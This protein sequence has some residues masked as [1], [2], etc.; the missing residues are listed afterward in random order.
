MVVRLPRTRIGCAMH[1][2]RVGIRLLGGHLLM[3]I[4]VVDQLTML[5]APR[6]LDQDHVAAARPLEKQGQQACEDA[7]APNHWGSG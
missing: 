2:R 3:C 5:G 4:A 1:R 7:S 6:V